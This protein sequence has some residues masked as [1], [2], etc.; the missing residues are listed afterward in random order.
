MLQ[1]L[2]KLFALAISITALAATAIFYRVIV[3]HET[4]TRTDGQTDEE[5]VKQTNLGWSDDCSD[6]PRERH[7]VYGIEGRMH[8]RTIAR[9]Q[10]FVWIV[11][12][13]LFTSQLHR[14][15]S[16]MFRGGLRGGERG[17]QSP[18]PRAV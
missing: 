13:D 14:K 5:T 10:Y 18:P 9:S 8:G 1:C 4:N 17:G 16:T 3:R 12:N 7:S 2:L 11:S 6:G 15:A